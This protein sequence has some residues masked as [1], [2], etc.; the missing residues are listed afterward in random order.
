MLVAGEVLSSS[1]FRVAASSALFLV[2]D[3]QQLFVRSAT[4]RPLDTRNGINRF[5]WLAPKTATFAGGIGGVLRG[6]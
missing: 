5:M 4:L 3:I 2:L 6:D 1:L